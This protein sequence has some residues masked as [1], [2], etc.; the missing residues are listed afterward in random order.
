MVYVSSTNG[1]CY[2]R[3]DWEAFAFGLAA[4]AA[5]DVVKAVSVLDMLNNFDRIA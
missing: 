3:D 1:K 4:F 5:F 2:D